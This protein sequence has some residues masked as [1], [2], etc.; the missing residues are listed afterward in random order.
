MRN[1]NFIRAAVTLAFASA[2]IA[3]TITEELA[4]AIANYSSLSL[5][6]S[7]LTAS[8]QALITSLDN[9]D[10]N[11]T[12]LVPTN[13]AIQSYLK[14]SRIFDVTELNQTE[15]QIFFSYHILDASLTSKDFEGDRG[16]SI[17][18]LLQ[19]TLFN[20]RSAG[21]QI[22]S[23]FGKEASGQVIFAL[24]RDGKDKRQQNEDMGGPN[25]MLRAG[26]AQDIKMTAVDG[27]WGAKDVN[28]FQV[29]D[30]VLSPPRSCSNTVHTIKDPRLDALDAALI[31]TQLW[32]ALD[33]SKNV[34]C[35]AP[36]TEAFKN[37]G[38]PDV[39]LSKQD[40]TGAI[41]AHTLNEVTYSNYLRDGQVIGTLNKTKVRVSIRG[42]DIFFNNAKVIEANVLTNNGLI[43]ILDSVIEDGGKPNSTGTSTT[44][45]ETATATGETTS[46]SGSE[47]AEQEN[48]ASSRYLPTHHRFSAMTVP[49]ERNSNVRL[50]ACL[51]DGEDTD[52]SDYR[53]LVDEQHVKYI[54]TAPG[55]FRGA[56][57]DRTFKP[58]LLGELLPLFP[59]G[60]WN[61]GH[62]ARDPE[63]GKATFVRTETVQFGQV[64]NTWHP[65]KLNELGF[66]RQVRLRQRV[67]VSTHPQVGGGK[68]V[69]IKFAV[70]PW[71][72]PSIEVE[73]AAYRWL[74]DTGVGPKF[75]DISP[76][77]KRAV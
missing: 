13:A 2:A 68:P 22:Q 4:G 71:E 66:T 70:W 64:K 27:S 61:Q 46:P 56:E 45:S 14:E 65:V 35:L 60:D 18:T 34:T 38:N 47:T 9:R 6:R 5:F 51:V 11:I 63:T 55:T 15:L 7:L 42:E 75:W 57:D 29:V 73:T 21:P 37:A 41:L 31:K 12:V 52:D 25:V 76:R 58:V 19:A 30:K 26:L 33:H 44:A 32:K 72:I 39:K 10:S 53:F 74:H 59:T 23:Q 36:S 54:T 1:L 8:P 24:K 69:P 77:V 3:Q 43:H 67:H 49:R 17:P 20:N 16:L 62:V 28:S 50:L 48:S 40:L